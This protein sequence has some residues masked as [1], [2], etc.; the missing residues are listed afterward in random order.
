M[1]VQRALR[2][3]FLL[4]GFMVLAAEGC[5]GGSQPGTTP[6]TGGS[7]GG[8]GG[9]G[10]APADAGVGH[11]AGGLAGAGG[12]GG[13]AGSGGT[14]MGGAAGATVAG[15]EPTCAWPA[16][17]GTTQTV[18]STIEVSGAMDGGLKRYVAGTALGSGNQAENQ[19]P[20]FELADGATLS[21]VILGAP[22]ADGI[23]CKGG[24][25]LRNVWWED[26]GED[27]ATFEG[28]LASQI[29]TID[30]GG[31][32]HASDKIFQHNG[33]GT[34]VIQNFCAN[35][36]GKL[37]RSCGNCSVQH[38]RHVQVLN[39]S[40]TA[41]S[42][43]VVG[44]NDNYYDTADLHGVYVHG[45]ALTICQRYTGNNTGAEPPTDGSG[46]DGGFCR[47][48]PAKDIFYLK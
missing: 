30:G 3:A 8:T 18:N 16:A 43:A 21:N 31:A 9:G 15:S 34:M 22:A 29:M 20:V 5:G 12:R 17:V 48:D 4:S 32:Q 47:Y 24:C 28:T 10:G 39:V 35:D 45:K 27:A 19:L 2:L 7:A 1:L 25:T 37:Y 38:D 40:L 26:V 46:A 44:I 13:S 33:W 23:H 14:G 6:G 41:G 36:Y 42:V 11:D